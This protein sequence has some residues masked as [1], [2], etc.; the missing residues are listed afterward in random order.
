MCLDCY[1]F[2]DYE[3]EDNGIDTFEINNY[4]TEDAE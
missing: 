1:G 3:I 4:E 2:Y